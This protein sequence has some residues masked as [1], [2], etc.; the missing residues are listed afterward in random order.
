MKLSLP[1]DGRAPIILV[2]DDQEPNVR[3]LGTLLSQAGYD[4][5]PAMS[6]PAA[7]ARL[8]A[9]VPDLVL[10]DRRMPGMDGFAVL[11][12]LRADPRTAATPVIVITA[13]DDPADLVGA[14]ERGAVDFVSKPFV[15][16]ELLA[17]VRTHVD[18][19][20]TRDHLDAVARE[21]EEL[22]AVIAHDLRNPLS[23]ILF[24]S[25]MLAQ[26]TDPDRVRA[27]A[28][29]IGHSGEA[30]LGFI[31]RFLERRAEGQLLREFARA[32]VALLAAAERAIDAV[33]M[34][35]EAKSQTIT[36]NERAPAEATGDPDAVHSILV[37]LLSNA[38][39]YAPPETPIELELGEA[40]DGHARLM[41]L[42]R[43][44]GLDD[45]QRSRLFRR[46]VRLGARPTAGEHSSGLG[47]ALA[48][49]DALQLGGR[50][51]HEPRVGG[52][53]A[54]GLDLPR[55]RGTDAA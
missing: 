34:G 29:G 53:S 16:A 28:E 40:P 4:V 27:L 22:A 47:L 51:W 55:W 17:R 37:N 48:M 14:F 44:P 49:Q 8:D 39:K 52:G 42:D 41:V 12:A 23:N 21:R 54:F 6:G 3:L 15:A 38:V 24:A 36:V 46:F 30:A 13:S 50:I 19:K 20:F 5:V 26:T 33:R 25:R 11:E 18:L 32:R 35:A 31:A 1:R 2:V 45:S 9:H 7:L 10:L 43:G